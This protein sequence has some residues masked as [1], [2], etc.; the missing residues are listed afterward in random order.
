MWVAVG[1]TWFLLEPLNQDQ[2]LE[3]EFCKENI[4]KCKNKNQ[5]GWKKGTDPAGEDPVKHQGSQWVD[6][7]ASSCIE[8]IKLMNYHA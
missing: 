3:Y 6:C 2:I 5:S 8:I 1:S 4:M 7:S